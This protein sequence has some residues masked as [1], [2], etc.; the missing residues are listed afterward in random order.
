[1]VLGFAL[2]AVVAMVCVSQSRVE[3]VARGINGRWTPLR[4]THFNRHGYGKDSAE[5]NRGLLI[6][7]SL[8][9]LF[10]LSIGL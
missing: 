4:I 10:G 5:V 1:V 6:R 2:R 7:R 9:L 8:L 3:F